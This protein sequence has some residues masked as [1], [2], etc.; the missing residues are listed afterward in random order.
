MGS[1]HNAAYG[2]ISISSE[3]GHKRQAAYR[4]FDSEILGGV[5]VQF[6]VRDAYK[7]ISSKRMTFYFNGLFKEAY[8]AP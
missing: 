3:T 5:Q 6:K 1:L 2:K 8:A 7:V 4:Q